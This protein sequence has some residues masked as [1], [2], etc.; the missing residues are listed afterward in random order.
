MRACLPWLLLLTLCGCDDSTATAPPPGPRQAIA[1]P[2]ALLHDFGVIPH[3]KAA[4]HQFVLDTRSLGDFV[5]VGVRADCSCARSTMALRAA[6]GSVRPITGQPL[7]EFAARDGEQLVITV[8]IDTVQK[9]AVDLA[10]VQSHATVELQPVQG[11]DAALR[12]VRWPLVFRFGV[13]AP[14]KLQPFAVLD[15]ERIPS[16]TEKQVLTTLRSDLPERAIVFG[17]A[18]CDDPRVRLQ[19]EPEGERTVLRATWTPAAGDLGPFRALVRV[20]T[21]LPDGY[22]VQIAA[23]GKVVPD[24]EATPFAKISLRADLQQPQPESALTVQSVLVTDHDRRR[25]PEFVITEFV[26]DQGRDANDRFEVRLSQVDGDPRS[27]R[28]GIRGLGGATGNFRGRLVL[29]KDPQA[30]PFLP[31]EIVAFHVPRP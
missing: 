27:H 10:P 1:T 15:F 12:R 3:G 20:A 29:A 25:A 24:L 9:E 18:T 22:A 14:V 26:D 17:P 13:D 31:I 19:L 6:D 2:K 23:V 7:P 21:D 8:Q 4:E 11:H 16:G 30:G 5:A 28:V